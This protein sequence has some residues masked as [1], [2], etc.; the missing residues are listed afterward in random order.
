MLEV[1]A[2]VERDAVVGDPASRAHA[3]G[4]ELVTVAPRARQTIDASALGFV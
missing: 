2:H 3:D 4:G 1:R